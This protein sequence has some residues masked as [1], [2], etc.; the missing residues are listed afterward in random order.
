MPALRQAGQ[1]R[2]ARQDEGND[3]MRRAT[4]PLIKLEDRSDDG[5]MVW[6]VYI[7]PRNFPL[8]VERALDDPLRDQLNAG[9]IEAVVVRDGWVIG[10][11]SLHD[12]LA[13]SIFQGEASLYVEADTIGGRRDVT[14]LSPLMID[15]HDVV[16]H[17]ATLGQSTLWDG[18][19]V[20]LG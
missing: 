9:M 11:G 19:E 8:P 2:V 4:Y 14:S 20:T 3:L 17:H 6:S 5:R 16:L 10:E 7:D 13:M 15:L 1:T 12:D 18:C